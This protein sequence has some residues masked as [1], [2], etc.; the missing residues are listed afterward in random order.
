MA[1]NNTQKYN[2]LFRYIIIGS[3]AVGKSQIIKRFTTDTFNEKYGATIG[4]EYDE[5]NIE[6]EGKITRIQIWDTAGQERFKSITRGYYKNCVCAIIVYDITSRESFNDITNWIKDCKNYS[7]KTV[8]MAL[9]GNKCDLEENRLI[10][11]EEGQQLADKNEITF[12]ETSAKEG[13]NIK[14]VFQKTGE[15]IYQNIKNKYY[16][17]DDISCGIKVNLSK[18]ESSS[19][20]LKKENDMEKEKEECYC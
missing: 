2:Y 18:N 17:L 13:T 3:T 5:K 11:T 7:P 15:K 6:I 12:Y 1:A 9:I 16:N 14:E 19:I 20:M 10:S 4:V 8:L